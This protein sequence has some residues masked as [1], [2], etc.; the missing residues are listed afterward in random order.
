MN[1]NE[2]KE[3]ATDEKDQQF[4][5]GC[6]QRNFFDFSQQG[7][8]RD[9]EKTRTIIKMRNWRKH[10]IRKYEKMRNN[11]WKNQEMLLVTFRELFFHQGWVRIMRNMSDQC[12]KWETGWSIKNLLLPAA[13]FSDFSLRLCERNENLKH[14]ETFGSLE[15]ILSDTG[16]LICLFCISL[17]VSPSLRVLDLLGLSFRLLF[18]LFLSFSHSHLS[19]SLFC[20]CLSVLSLYLSISLSISFSLSL[21]MHTYIY[22]Y[23]YMAITSISGPRKG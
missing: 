8:V 13:N 17:G 10:P 6:I 4:A 1:K 16:S 2:K 11:C 20:F 18:Y 12:E 23:T 22:I 9:H 5:S 3:K 19:Y 15:D 14:F 7:W 21:C